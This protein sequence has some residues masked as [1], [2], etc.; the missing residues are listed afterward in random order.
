MSSF[1][2]RMSDE[3]LVVGYVTIRSVSVLRQPTSNVEQNNLV[4]KRNLKYVCLSSFTSGICTAKRISVF[5]YFNILL[6][7]DA[8]FNDQT[9]MIVFVYLYCVLKLL[10]VNECRLHYL[11]KQTRLL[12]I[13]VVHCRPAA[14]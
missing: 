7:I 5:S 2:K 11:T 13:F 1:E 10:T 14:L 3:Q 6:H 12:L 8:Q 4:S 9:S